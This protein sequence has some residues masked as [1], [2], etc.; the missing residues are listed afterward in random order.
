MK[1]SVEKLSA[2][3]TKITVEVPFEELKP[4]FDKAYASL[5]QQV[6]MPGFRKGTQRNCWR[7]VWV[8]A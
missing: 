2:T 4:E 1:S 8:V 6:N 5:A 7:L 3:R